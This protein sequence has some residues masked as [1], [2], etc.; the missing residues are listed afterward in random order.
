MSSTTNTT[1]TSSGSTPN[2][3]AKVSKNYDKDDDERIPVVIKLKSAS[4]APLS[5]LT[6]SLLVSLIAGFAVY[7]LITGFNNLTKYLNGLGLFVS[8]A[9]IV[10][11]V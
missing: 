2:W 6:E 1:T 3:A 8:S 4:D 9:E 5:P 11:V 7:G 10:N